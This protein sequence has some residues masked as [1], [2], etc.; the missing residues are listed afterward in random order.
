MQQ[1]KFSL[2]LLICNVPSSL[3]GS[4]R[5]VLNSSQAV[6]NSSLVVRSFN[7]FSSRFIFSFYLLLTHPLR[8]KRARHQM[9]LLPCELSPWMSFLF[10]SPVTQGKGRKLSSCVVLLS[11]SVLRLLPQAL[12]H[13]P[14]SSS[15]FLRHSSFERLQRLFS[16]SSL[17]QKGKGLLIPTH[18]SCF[19]FFP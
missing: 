13:F 4:S 19:L 11:L 5:D 12:R 18:S 2:F 6:E 15:L 17:A 8:T 14:S 3:A 9:S 10:A 16:L 7:F 1:R